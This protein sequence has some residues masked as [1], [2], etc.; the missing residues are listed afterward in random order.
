MDVDLA[1]STG[2][3]G[4]HLLRSYRQLLAQAEGVEVTD[5]VPHVRNV[6]ALRCPPQDGLEVQL[7]PLL[8]DTQSSL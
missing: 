1:A 3:A 7:E 8:R 4:G 5:P 2:E 6:A